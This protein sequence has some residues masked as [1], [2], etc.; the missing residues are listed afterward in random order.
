MTDFSIKSFK[1]L[2]LLE[3]ILSSPSCF[4]S[5][6]LQI[7]KIAQAALNMELASNETRASITPRDSNPW[8]VAYARLVQQVLP[9]KSRFTEP[10][11]QGQNIRRWKFALVLINTS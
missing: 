2:E 9:Y 1:I 3:V 10:G 11:A 8:L 4:A 5:R 6:C 7:P